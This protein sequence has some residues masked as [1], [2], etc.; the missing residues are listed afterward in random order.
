MNTY[1]GT[2]VYS[3]AHL[4]IIKNRHSGTECTFVHSK[5]AKQVVTI[6]IPLL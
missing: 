6:H 1:P 5:Y 4:I 2:C 3:I